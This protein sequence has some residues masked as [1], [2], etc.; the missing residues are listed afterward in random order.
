MVRTWRWVCVSSVACL[1]LGCPH[2]NSGQDAGA[3]AAPSASAAPEAAP[4]AAAN[5]SDVTKY[6]DQNPDNMAPLTARVTVN[7]RTETGSTGGKLVGPIKAGTQVSEV[8]DH[9]GYDLVVYPDPND[10][11]HN[12]E[13]WAIHTAFVGDTHPVVVTDGGV[14]PTPPSTG[15]VCVKQIGPNKCPPGYAVSGAVCRVPCSSAGDCH[16]P[17]PKCNEGKCYASNGCD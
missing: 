1:L 6:P 15:Y 5:D 4:P 2:K 13:G 10:S 11:T 12:L 8:A 17:D 9:E 16:G 14:K 7:V 3:D